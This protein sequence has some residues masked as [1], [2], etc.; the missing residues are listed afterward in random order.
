MNLKRLARADRRLIREAI[1]IIDKGGSQ[2]SFRR[3]GWSGPHKGV[4]KRAFIKGGIVVKYGPDTQL[5]EELRLWNKTSR[6]KSYRWFRK[7]LARVFGIYNGWIFQRFID[8][9]RYC[10][11]YNKCERIANRMRIGDF[12]NHNHRHDDRGRPIWFDTNTY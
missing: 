12:G 9:E 5:E 8:G 2:G 7:H 11:D 10:E 1:S 4:Y 3:N 6:L